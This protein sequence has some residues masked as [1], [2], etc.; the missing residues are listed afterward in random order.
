MNILQK[1]TNEMHHV[2]N[3]RLL[4]LCDEHQI[5]PIDHIDLSRL[6]T[7]EQ[8]HRA[9]RNMSNTNCEKHDGEN[10]LDHFKESYPALSRGLQADIDDDTHIVGSF[11]NDYMM[12][13]TVKIN[14]PTDP[15]EPTGL[16]LQL[17]EAFDAINF[18][19]DNEDECDCNH[20]DE[21]TCTIDADDL[22][23]LVGSIVSSLFK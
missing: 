15:F 17:D 2:L 11:L 20:D 9:V 18:D 21:T 6:A 19:D 16:L 8:L 3:E 7:I 12:D 10:Y 14:V 22:G 23:K 13:P 1:F 5:S 4:T